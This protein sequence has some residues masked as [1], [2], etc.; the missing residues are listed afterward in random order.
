MNRECEKCNRDER[1]ALFHNGAQKEKVE[2]VRTD[3]SKIREDRAA[4]TAELVKIAGH[5]LCLFTRENEAL[6]KLLVKAK[7]AIHDQSVETKLVGKLREAAIHYAKK[8]DLLYPHLS[9]KYGISGP[10]DVMWTVDDEIRDELAGLCKVMTFTE[11]ELKRLD[12]VIVRMEEMIFK[13]ANILF[14]NC[15][16]NFT[17]EEWIRIYH[18][19][20]DYPVCLGVEQ[21]KWQEAEDRAQQITNATDAEFEIVMDG[22]HMTVGQLSAML[23]TMPFEITFVDDKNINRYFNDGP[24]DFKRP[25]M[26]IDREVF[27]CHPPMIATKVRHIIEEFRAGTLD[28]VPVFMEKNGKMMYVTYLAVRNKQGAYLGTLELVQDMTFVKEYLTRN[29]NQL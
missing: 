21:E 7:A 11:T 24:K 22:G 1:A 15:A 2:D 28:K 17:N 19:T 29:W 5:P 16:V 20:K 23:N 18:D 10:A 8:G 14:P 12:A 3:A 25:R 13:E 9:V 6:E 26:S 27:S 4:K